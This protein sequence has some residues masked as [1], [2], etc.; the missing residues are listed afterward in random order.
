[1]FTTASFIAG[2]ALA[3]AAHANVLY[4]Q[5]W[6]GGGN[7]FASQNDTTG[8]NGNFATVFDDFTL[9]SASNLNGFDF[10]GG[11]FNPPAQGPITGFTLTFYADAAGAPGAAIASGFF[12]G[13]GNE[14]FLN[15]NSG[16]PTYE[17]SLFF[18]NFPVAA[19]TYWASIV[20]DLGFPPQWG[21]ATSA[22]GNNNAYQTFL[23]TTSPLGVNMAF[24]VLGAPGVP[25]P[26]TW[27]L[28]LVGFGLVG[29]S[30]RRRS[31]PATA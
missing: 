8:G 11:Y 2:L 16:F 9:S 10:T 22:V 1:M 20:P 5:P 21:W 19:G 27:G 6:D 13:T 14:T 26:A 15:A 23:G 3:G 31:A 30:L 24:D 29:S 7:L 17:Y 18:N 25:E 12:P 28:M 4:S